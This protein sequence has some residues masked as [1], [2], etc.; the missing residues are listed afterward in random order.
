MPG[1]SYLFPFQ[2]K[3]YIFFIF[4]YTFTY[5][6]TTEVTKD[7]VTEIKQKYFKGKLWSLHLSWLINSIFICS[8]SLG[9][10]FWKVFLRDKSIFYG[11]EIFCILFRQVIS[12]KKM[13]MWSEKITISIS[14][15]S[16]CISLILLLW[17]RSGTKHDSEF[18][19]YFR[20]FASKTQIRMYIIYMNTTVFNNTIVYYHNLSSH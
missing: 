17:L 5:F 3:W 19:Y 4:H 11:F 7:R 15:F 2:R 14:W 8:T 20:L 1:R 18:A 12:L 6:V 10:G 13:V 9:L 16:V